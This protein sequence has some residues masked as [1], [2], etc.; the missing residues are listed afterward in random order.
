VDDFTIKKH[1]ALQLIKIIS[2]V[3]CLWIEWWE[4]PNPSFKISDEVLG[5]NMRKITW[6]NSFLH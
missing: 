5:F 6:K 4:G 3:Q 2:G 1:R